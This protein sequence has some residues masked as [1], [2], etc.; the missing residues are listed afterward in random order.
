MP[1]EDSDQ[2]DQDR[3]SSEDALDLF[4]PTDRPAKTDQTARM[5]RLI[6]VFAVRTSNTVENAVSRLILFM[7]MYITKFLYPI[8]P[9]YRVPFILPVPI[10]GLLDS[11]G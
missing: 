2:S 7:I 4:Q 9:M 3:C 8:Y 6:S 11:R 1:S 5:R 10:L